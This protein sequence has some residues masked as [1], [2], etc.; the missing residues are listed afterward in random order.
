MK[1]IKANLKK[2]QPSNSYDP[3]LYY[4]DKKFT[5]CDCGAKEVWKAEQQQWWY[6]VWRGSIHAT[7]NRCRSCRQ[8]VREAKLEQKRRMKEAAAKKQ[9]K[10]EA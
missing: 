9:P 6:E 7:A 1:R 5:C 4:T 2:Q 10:P 3:K 8:K